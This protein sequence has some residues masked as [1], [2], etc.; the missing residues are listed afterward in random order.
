M[1][2]F[3]KADKNVNP[4]SHTILS[5][6]HLSKALKQK[7][8]I[9]SKKY[10]PLEIDPSLTIAEK[11][12]LMTEWWE[13]AHELLIN[14]RITED[15]IVKLAK[16]TPVEMRPGLKDIIFRCKDNDI[17]FLVFSAGIE[18]I[19]EEVLRSKNLYHP[20][21]HIVANKMLLDPSEGI[22]NKFE[23]PL[24]HVF[25][26]SEIMIEGTPYYSTLIEKNNVILLGDSLG[27]L[28]MSKGIKHDVRLTIGFLNVRVDELLN[29]YLN[30]YDIVVTNDGS[31][32]I[33]AIMIAS[34]NLSSEMVDFFILNHYTTGPAIVSNI[35]LKIEDLQLRLNGREILIQI[36]RLG[37]IVKLIG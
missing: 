36:K 23:E 35:L 20:N 26:K 37:N 29:D 14:E 11:A 15:D 4:S 12:P 21:M 1:T 33:V 32:D 10:Y 24:I 8:K 18:N 34:G 13:K 25:S 31:M 6:G 9:L 19:I 5:D 16:E 28:D 7:M 30:A 2:R 17:P 22:F 3:Y 27:D